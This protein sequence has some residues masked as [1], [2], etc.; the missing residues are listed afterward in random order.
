MH[1]SLGEV[2]VAQERCRIPAACVDAAGEERPPRGILVAAKTVVQRTLDG[3]ELNFQHF[4][5]IGRQQS[6]FVD[7][8]RVLA[9][10]ALE[11][12][13]RAYPRIRGMFQPVGDP[14]AARGSVSD[15][16]RPGGIGVRGGVGLFVSRVVDVRSED[17][18]DARRAEIAEFSADTVQFAKM[19]ENRSVV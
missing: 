5:A 1:T 17:R 7:I 3:G 15:L 12:R 13:P 4:T 16:F 6:G 8:I 14:A 2:Q 18:G 10:D 19:A 11:V 9:D